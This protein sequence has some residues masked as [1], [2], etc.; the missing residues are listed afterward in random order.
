MILSKYSGNV[1][2]SNWWDVQ[3]TF[4]YHGYIQGGQE[5]MQQLW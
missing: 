4:P 5:R 2:Q 3:W 1:Y